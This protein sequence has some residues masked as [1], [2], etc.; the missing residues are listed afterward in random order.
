MKKIL[1]A[2]LAVLALCVQGSGTEPPA[3]KPAAQPEVETLVCIRHGEK[4]AGGLGQLNCRGLNRA[5]A[6]PK[7]L[8]SRYG[9]PKFIF[10]PNPTQ[11]ADKGQY[12][13]IR[14]LAT[15]EPTAIRLGMPVDTEFGFE[16]IKQLERELEKPAYHGAT[17]FVAWEHIKLDDF[18]KLLV[19]RFGGDAAQVPAWPHDD[20]DSIFVFKIT[21]EGKKQSVA[22]SVEHEGLDGQPEACP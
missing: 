20:Y 15:I 14:P 11:K 7:V 9:D 4:P 16:Q 22:F 2:F 6:L 12:Y 19:K 8:L 10:A 13:Y 5:L 3:S 21:R 17:V 1:P 18:A